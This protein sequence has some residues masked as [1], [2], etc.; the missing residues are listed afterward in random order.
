MRL[1]E[2]RITGTF[3]ASLINSRDAIQKNLGKEAILYDAHQEWCHGQ[4]LTT[5]YDDEVY[6]MRI[7]DTRQERQFH[8]HDLEKLMICSKTDADRSETGDFRKIL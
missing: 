8:Y 3:G 6:R 4:I 1:R 2:I 7:F 5:G